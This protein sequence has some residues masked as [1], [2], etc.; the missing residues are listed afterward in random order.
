M[1]LSRQAFSLTL[2]QAVQWGEMDAFQHVNNSVYFQ[3][4]ENARIHYFEETGINAYMA[5]HQV[6]PILGSTECKFLAP[7]TWPDTVTVATRVTA[8]KEKRFSMQYTV[9]SDK[10]SREVATGSGEIIFFD[11]RKQ[12]TCLIPSSIVDKIEQFESK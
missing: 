8:I 1:T 2:S 11:Y 3:Y 10:L 5:S 4:F 6:G 7:L 12:Q 9:F